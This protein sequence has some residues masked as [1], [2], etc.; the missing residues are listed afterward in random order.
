MH[1]FCILLL[2]N[3]IQYL[4]WILVTIITPRTLENSTGRRA[5][6]CNPEQQPLGVKVVHQS[7]WSVGGSL[8]CSCWQIVTLL[9][10]KIQRAAIVSYYS[11]ELLTFRKY[12]RF[13]ILST[14]HQYVMV[15]GRT[16]FVDGKVRKSSHPQTATYTCC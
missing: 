7:L 1:A 13:L 8:P 6:C 12:N 16:K 15:F 11:K 2:H 5:L 9:S 3:W 4:N 10:A 14:K